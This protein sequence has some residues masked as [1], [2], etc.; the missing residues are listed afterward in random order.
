MTPERRLWIA[1][2]TQ[3]VLDFEHVLRRLKALND[4]KGPQKVIDRV[5]RDLDGLWHEVHHEWFRDICS[6]AKVHPDRVYRGIRRK[7]KSRGL[8]A[9]LKGYQ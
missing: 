7:Y 3:T 9:Y 6:F 5:S 8:A 2:I 4:R 1:V